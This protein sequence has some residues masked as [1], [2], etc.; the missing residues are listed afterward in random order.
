MWMRSSAPAKT[1]STDRLSARR[2]RSVSQRAAE[3][4]R[5][6]QDFEA[7]DAPRQ[8]QLQAACG[9]RYCVPVQSRKTHV[10]PRVDVAGGV[11][12]I[13]EIERHTVSEGF[14]VVHV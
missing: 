5:C 8:V 10:Q 9:Q 14:R 4:G 11:G 7:D 13:D 2:T 1:P 3:V 6:P 12:I